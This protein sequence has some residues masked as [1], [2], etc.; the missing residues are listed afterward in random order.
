MLKL[1]VRYIEC[2]YHRCRPTNMN[3]THE[4]L[5][6]VNGIAV[7]QRVDDARLARLSATTVRAWRGLYVPV[8]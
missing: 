7:F 2:Q 3:V 4:H 5:S 8:H 1:E 6:I